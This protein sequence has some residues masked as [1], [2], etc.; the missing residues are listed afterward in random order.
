MLREVEM[1]D[2]RVGVEGAGVVTRTASDVTELEVAGHYN[3]K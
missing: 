3:P 1:P 2:G